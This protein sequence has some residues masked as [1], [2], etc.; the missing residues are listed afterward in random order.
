[1][2][3]HG[4]EPPSRLSKGPQAL[5]TIGEAA[6]ELGLEAHV[7]RFWETKFPALQ[8]L[9]QRGGRRL[10][11]PADMELL[12]R[13][14]GLLHK[15]GYTIRGAQRLL[16]DAVIK[17]GNETA[18]NGRRRA[19]DS[20]RARAKPK[21]PTAPSPHKAGKAEAAIG[22]RDLQAA[23]AAAAEAGAFG[24]ETGTQH[25]LAPEEKRRL[26]RALDALTALR[27]RLEAHRALPESAR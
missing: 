26:G 10:Y 25:R 5:R 16:G 12:R 8:P 21:Q 22:P 3:D 14:Q 19:P 6:G 17:T 15:D 27:A 23:V 13:V 7:L 18:G 1:M 4:Q 11:R 9:K 24:T 2:S 20:P